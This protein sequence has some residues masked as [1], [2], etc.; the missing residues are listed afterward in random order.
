MVDLLTQGCVGEYMY[1]Q[2]TGIV[3]VGLISPSKIKQHL[4]FKEIF[5][6][7]MQ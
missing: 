5:P 2:Q 4:C 6:W 7:L 3:V 1:P